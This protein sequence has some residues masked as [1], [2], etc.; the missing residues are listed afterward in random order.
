MSDDFPRNTSIT[1]VTRRVVAAACVALVA[2]AS[3]ALA[4][5]TPP[6]GG[7]VVRDCLDNGRL[8]RHYRDVDL[9]AA[10]KALAPDV[11][12]YSACPALI[13]S[14]RAVYLGGDGKPG[15]SAVVND[16]AAHGRLRARYSVEQLHAAL[17]VLPIDVD[18]HT[19]C[20]GAIRSQL[21][22]LERPVSRRA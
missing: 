2:S 7:P 11:E 1:T 17:K 3:P 18:D 5:T 4:G 13:A 9:A 20:R 19:A 6:A 8:D 10:S 16:C 22:A 12:D 14:Q 21:S 15:A